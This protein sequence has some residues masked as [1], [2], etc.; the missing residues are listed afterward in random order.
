M[1][2]KPYPQHQM[3]LLPQSLDELIEPG[4][5]CRV[6]D[7]FVEALP[8]HR[9][10]EQVHN[11]EG[12]SKYHPRMMLKV[13]LYAYTQN[14]KSSRRIARHMRQNVC[15][16]WLAG[17]QRPSHNTVNRFRSTYLA[18][19]MASL[20]ASF[21]EMAMDGGL[22]E[23]EDYFVDGTKIEANAGK[24]THVWAKNTK[25]YKER[26]LQRAEEIIAEAEALD[27]QEDER[28]QGADLPESGERKQLSAE[29][30][31]EVARSLGEEPSPLKQKAA[32]RLEKEAENV[33]KYED[34]ER[35][36]A[37][38]NSYSKTDVDATFMRTKE[39]LVRP[40][41]N[42][43]AGTQG[44][45]VTGL[46]IHQ[47]SHDGN[48]FIDHM[49]SRR[50]AGFS[51]ASTVV[52]DAG[53]GH[54]ANYQYCES[55][56]IEAYLK[57]P[58]FYRESRG[59]EGPYAK[60]AFTYDAENDRFVC[61][62]N[63]TL[64][65]TEEKQNRS[66]NGYISTE[67]RYVATQCGECPVQGDCTRSGQ[68]TIRHSLRLG[69]YRKEARQRLESPRGQELS[70]RRGFEIETVFAHLKHNLG[71]RRFTLR[72]LEKVSA[73][74][75]LHVLGYNLRRLWGKLQTNGGP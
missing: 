11:A 25:R 13:L 40:A 23:S 44:G 6:V 66:S 38:R 31:R 26:T 62:C 45:F 53:F 68:R 72:G 30:I 35:K 65:F 69:A 12:C 19:S 71:L 33:E 54:E 74:I 46:S 9:V 17:M 7:A 50:Q 67:R 36:L 22:M 64:E 73:E 47:N 57:Y 61:P 18:P 49:E 28:Y 15:F 41:Y 37:G 14:I 8:R 39:E 3:L 42:V 5:L 24:Y 1:A 34:Q 4:D 43:M 59:K 10:E 21:A 2:F 16:M 32:K 75:H 58:S 27:R 20:L 55:E 70:R 51:P 56:N 60:S 52:G 29:R 48:A 63:K